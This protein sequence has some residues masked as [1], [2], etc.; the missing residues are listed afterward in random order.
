MLSALK[1][2]LV[3]LAIGFGSSAVSAAEADRHQAA[4][5]AL[6]EPWNKSDGP[7]AAISVMLDGQIVASVAVGSAD[8]EHRV[9]IRPRSVFHAASL[10]KQVTAFAILLLEQDGK[11]SIDDP[12]SK[13]L[14]EAAVLG[15]ITL[16]QLLNHTSGL[17]DQYTL[18]AAAGWR[19]EDLVTDQQA[20]AI[21]LAQRGGNSAPG[22]AYQ[23]INSDYTL[24]GEV[25]RRLSGKT[26]NAFCK[27]RI[28]EPLGMTHTR[29]QDDVAAI[30][31]DRVE[32][33][34]PVAGGYSRAILSYA[35]TG[36]T[37]L[38]TTA[39]DLNRWS[40]NLETGAV[41]GTRLTHRMEERGVLAD[42]TV[43]AYAM[44][45]DHHRYHGLT[46]WMHGGRDAG[47]RSFLLRVPSEHLSVA[48]LS[49][50]ANFNSGAIASAIAD[51]Y[52]AGKPGYHPVTSAAPRSPTSRQ[53][54]SY[55]GTYE[56]FPGLIFTIST[57]GQRLLITPLGS[58]QPSVL[59][60]LSPA[61][62]QEDP[63]S[64]ITIEFPPPISGKAQGFTYRVGLDGIIEARR[65]TLAAFGTVATKPQEY[66]GR[67]YSPE[68]KT[69]YELV[70]VDSVLIARN[71]RRPDIRLRP[72]QRDTFSG[73]EWFF[74]R[75][76]FTRGNNGSVVGFQLSG[77]NAEGIEFT[78][79]A[80]K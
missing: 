67:Y 66:A 64:G 70:V 38:Q 17:R 9:P 73:S 23:Y 61:I 35:T 7:G 54:A 12:L 2:A 46:A 22:K 77:V 80:L 53:L 6:L 19:S 74:Q 65:V 25:M 43:N 59:P 37:N 72:Y 11:L 69:E 33:Y 39:E 68:L 32:S 15:P 55:T 29:F 42:G 16:R 8:L 58:T 5:A 34:R 36:P 3:A 10:S 21:I 60:A 13:Y 48:V 44:G 30:I 4:I 41:G 52:L 1:Y 75:V 18:L 28:F 63:K 51:I 56:L 62:F 27:E 78:R 79:M 24:L 14:P 31:P 40:R 47:F 50:V 57:D 26:L 76:E 49:N 20:I 71:I 45:Q